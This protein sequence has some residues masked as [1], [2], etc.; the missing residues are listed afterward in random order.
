ME[1]F[2]TRHHINV[3][4][5]SVLCKYIEKEI[6]SGNTRRAY[7]LNSVLGYLTLNATCF[8]VSQENGISLLY[9]EK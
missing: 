8:S 1:N 3:P 5:T 9:L 6:V 7:H 2:I 4:Q